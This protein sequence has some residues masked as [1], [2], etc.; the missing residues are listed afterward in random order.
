MITVTVFRTRRTGCYQGFSCEGHA[1]YAEEG[2]DIVCA[3]VSALTLNTINS[4]EAFTDDVFSVEQAEDG[5]YLKITLEGEPSDKTALLMDSMVL[6]L[7][8]IQE[9]Y[10]NAYSRLTFKEV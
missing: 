5:G 2:Q 10:G 1:E 8:S 3:A 6:G 4:I 7:N 9:N